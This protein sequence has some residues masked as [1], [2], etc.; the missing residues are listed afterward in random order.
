ME[1]ILQKGNSRAY[2]CGERN[3]DIGT[4][5]TSRNGDRK[6]MQSITI[7]SGTPLRIREWNKFSQFRW[8]SAKVL[9]AYK[10]LSGYISTTTQDLMRGSKWRT[11]NLV[12]ASHLFVTW[13]IWVVKV[14]SMG[15]TRLLFHFGMFALIKVSPY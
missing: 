15:V 10:T 8:K 13:L 3:C 14:S 9:P 12:C 11:C 5:T 6:I 4:L 1:S 2:L 7:T